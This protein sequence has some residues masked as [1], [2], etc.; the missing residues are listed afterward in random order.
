MKAKSYDYVYTGGDYAILVK[1]Q[2]GN[3][4]PTPA[5]L[6]EYAKVEFDGGLEAIIAGET[7][8][9]VELVF[10]DEDWA[11][12]A[13]KVLLQKWLPAAVEKAQARVDLYKTQQR[14]AGNKSAPELTLPVVLGRMREM[15]GIKVTEFW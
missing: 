5:Y 8:N 1:V 12:Y 13:H 11:S 3:R 9:L 15:T 10:K 6:I 4:E 14:F 7:H 2:L